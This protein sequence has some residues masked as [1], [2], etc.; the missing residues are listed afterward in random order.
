MMTDA[1]HANDGQF[2]RHII[3]CSPE[4]R[5]TAICHLNG[6]CSVCPYA[7]AYLNPDVPLHFFMS[8][9]GGD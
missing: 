1:A 3:A 6:K 5:G 2:S 4:I 8:K 9:N 7:L